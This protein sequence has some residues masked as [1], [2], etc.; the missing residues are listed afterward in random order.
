MSADRAWQHKVDT[1]ALEIERWKNE[2][3]YWRKRVIDEVCLNETLRKEN[4]ALSVKLHENK[5]R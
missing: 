1:M 5:I 4:L 3:G 2:A